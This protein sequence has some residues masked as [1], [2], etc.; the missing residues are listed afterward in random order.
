MPHRSNAAEAAAEPRDARAWAR[1]LHP[2]HVPRAERGIFEILVTALPLAALWTFMWLTLDIGY[3]AT[4]LLAIPTAGFLVRMFMIQHD[5][6]HGAFFRNKHA[7]EWIGRICGVFTLTPFTFWRR[8]HAIHH[9]GSGNLDRRGV[10]D[11]T[12]LTVAEY[13]ARSPLGRFLYRL[14]RNPLVLFVIGPAYMFLLHHRLPVGFM[15]KG[16]RPWAS[17]MGTNLTI[18]GLTVLFIWLIGY[19]AFLALFLPVVLLAASAGVWLFYVQHQFERTSWDE[20]EDWSWADAALRGSS[21]YDLPA[22][23]RWFTAN[24]GIHHVHH[25]SS[26]IPFYRLGQ[27]LRDYPELKNVSR[28]N[29]VQSLKCVRLGLWDETQRKLVTFGEARRALQAAKQQP[30]P[31]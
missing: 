16:W 10:G 3:W 7:N 2:Y 28:I 21:Y 20:E 17:T 24:I 13:Q 11:I 30:Q 22:V 18:A 5:C 8:T 12:T 31:S 6:S 27:V 9:A 26:R 23:L 14:Y 25:L 1:A 19:K 29:L 4:L 15:R